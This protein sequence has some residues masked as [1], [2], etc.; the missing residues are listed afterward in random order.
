MS[1]Q[2]KVPVFK[3]VTHPFM[4]AITSQYFFFSEDGLMWFSTAGGLTSF[5]GSEIIYYSTVQQSSGLGLHS[6]HAMAEDKEHNFYIGTQVGLL[7]YDRQQKKFDLL[8]YTFSDNQKQINIGFTAL[9]YDVNGIL[10]AGSA[11]NGLFLY[12]T[13]RKQFNHYNFDRLKPDSWQDRNLNTVESFAA[14]NTDNNKL[15]IGS[16]HGIYLFN[17]QEK[18]FSQ[19][20]EIVT[21]MT[22]KYNPNLR[23][24]QFIDVQRMDV[25]NDSMIW[26]NSW[27]GGFGYYNTRTG[28]ADMVFGRDALYKS[29]D[30]YYGY[31]IPKFSKLSANKYL[32][33][34]FTGKTAVFNTDTRSV[35]YFNVTNNNYS[36]EETR[37]VTNDRLGNTWLLQRGLLYVS[38]PESFRLQS[39]DVPNLTPVNFSKPKISGIFFDP[40]T[41]LFYATFLSSIG[42]HIYDS[43]FIQQTV[44]PTSLI[45]NYFS[46][47]STVDQSITKDGIGRFWTVGWNIY[48]LR[49]GEKKFKPVENVFPSLKWLKE[50][51]DF[52][53]VITTRDGN[54][55]LKK[56]DQLIYLINH[57]SIVTDT[58]RCPEMNAEGVEVKNASTWYDKKRDLAYLTRKKGIAQFNLSKK[59]MKIISR[60]ALF[61][62]LPSNQGACSLT[63]DFYGRIWFMIPKY[64]I[65]IIEPLSL[66]CIDS[67]KYGEKGLMGSDYTDIIGGA[68]NY[69]MFRSQNGI[70]VYDY[71]NRRSF[72]FDHSNGLSSPD[73]KTLFYSHGYLIIGQSGKFEY[74]KL[75][76]LDN[77]SARLK[78]NLN[79]I[80]SDTAV[81]F[82]DA[83]SKNNQEIKLQH[84]ENTIAF[85][86]SALEFFFPERTEYAYQIKPLNKD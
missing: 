39:V 57:V 28:K 41:Q 69:V 22:H 18:K 1:A 73:N 63:L 49:P 13:H 77:Y 53:D 54:I 52:S 29:K 62:G 7:H 76:A 27:A 47:A 59:E 68:E 16:N 85:S 70:I 6:I 61:G 4:P 25:A 67:I 50:K 32:L 17:K 38:V 21:N 55:L 2:D 3:Q 36:E 74:F 66:S 15:W 80:T 75:A 26:F 42:V 10:Y 5:D 33:G 65:R 14:H 12:D 60:A 44:I 23:D 46:Y 56:N 35:T 71:A 79:S 58:I 64:G 40:K 20:F 24:K 48:V 19:D 51:G 11:S 37:F 84:D 8:S 81:L 86:F 78:P 83:G 43:N 9:Y 31:I 72:V 82:T 34:I 30:L 45:Y